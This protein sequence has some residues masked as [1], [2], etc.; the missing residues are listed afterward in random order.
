MHPW[1]ACP[2]AIFCT[3]P[4]RIPFAGRVDVCCFDK[5]GS[6]IAEN[7]VLESVTYTEC[8]LVDVKE[9]RRQSFCVSWL[10]T[11]WSDWIGTVVGDSMEETTLESLGWVL[12]KATK[13]HP[14]LTRSMTAR[15]LEDLRRPF[16]LSSTLKRVCRLYPR[17]QAER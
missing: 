7:L 16:H 10:R 8:I 15:R 4:F 9:A 13:V 2:Y 14:G 17:C 12:D 1:L 6:T 5:T 3:E 11:P